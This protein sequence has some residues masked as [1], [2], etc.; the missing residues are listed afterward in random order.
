MKINNYYPCHISNYRAGR[1]GKIKYLAV[2]YVGA[3]GDAAAN[4]KY[5]GTTPKI[6]ASAH[7]FVGHG[8]KPE[9]WASVPEADT[10]WHCGANTYYHPEC[11]NYN[12]IG[13]EMCCHK[14]EDGTWYFDPET[15]DAAVELC[16]D[17]VR[18]Y[19]I[20]STHMLRHFDVTHKKC[21]APFVDDPAAW[22]DFKNRVLG[23]D[24]KLTKDDVWAIVNEALAKHTYATL[25]DI[26][27]YYR[28]AVDKLVKKGIL[29]GDGNALNVSED[30]CRTLTVLD[31]L[32]KLD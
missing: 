4:A 7:Y 30:L 19:S 3:T 25:A 13:V 5:Y 6:G 23:E 22:Q 20:D 15:V 24:S 9:I 31:R 16:R 32:G 27:A 26:P 8:P 28:A 1:K 11:R 21:P 12:S 29:N 18:R 2:H 14:R 10:A 17:I